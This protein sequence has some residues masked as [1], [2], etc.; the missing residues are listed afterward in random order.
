MDK[1]FLKFCFLFVECVNIFDDG[2]GFK[3]G[4]C[5]LGYIGDGMRCDDVDEVYK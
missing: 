2:F 4:E 3:C 1:C 5:L